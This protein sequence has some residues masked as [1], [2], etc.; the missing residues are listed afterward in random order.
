M[1]PKGWQL[2][3]HWYTCSS[4]SPQAVTHKTKKAPSLTKYIMFVKADT[5]FRK[6]QTQSFHREL[7]FSPPVCMLDAGTGEDCLWCKTGAMRKIYFWS[8]HWKQG[9]GSA[10]SRPVP[11]RGVP[12]DAMV[13]PAST[14]PASIA[15]LHSKARSFAWLISEQCMGWYTCGTY[16][17]SRISLTNNRVFSFSRGLV[18][19][20]TGRG[21]SASTSTTSTVT[22]SPL[23]R[24]HAPS[25][26]N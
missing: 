18:P 24:T 15:S 20:G 23:P 1:T 10:E 7:Y 11:V 21:W 22:T 3:S 13:L 26:C 17:T 14:K 4:F 12:E 5:L 19:T 8:S 2:K 16:R 9:D 25:P 6:L